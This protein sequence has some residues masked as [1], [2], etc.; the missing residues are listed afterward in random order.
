[1]YLSQKR[2]NEALPKEGQN[3]I[4]AYKLKQIQWSHNWNETK[5]Y[6]HIS[7]NRFNETKTD[8]GT[9]SYMYLNQN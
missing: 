2:F 9:R 7:Q 4:Y 1:M 8:I 5:S 3:H 6:M